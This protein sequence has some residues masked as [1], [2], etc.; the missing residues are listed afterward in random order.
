VLYR[1]LTG[2]PPHDGVDPHDLIAAIVTQAPVRP[3]ALA[4]LGAAPVA[5]DIDAVLAIA[6]AKAP[7]DRFASAGALARAFDEALGGHLASETRAHAAAL[8]AQRPWSTPEAR[9]GRRGAAH[10]EATRSG[11]FG[12]R[13]TIG[14]TLVAPGSAAATA[15]PDAYAATER[16]I[17]GH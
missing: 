7:G 6:L 9:V 10:H 13:P 15:V 8:L 3:S 5:E 16:D 11:Q 2:A 14:S 4:P 1:V 17:D 12:L